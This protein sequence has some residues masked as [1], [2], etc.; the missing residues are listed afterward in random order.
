V[1]FEELAV[2]KEQGDEWKSYSKYVKLQAMIDLCKKL[3]Y[4]CINLWLM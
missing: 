1:G 3:G 2:A 4:G